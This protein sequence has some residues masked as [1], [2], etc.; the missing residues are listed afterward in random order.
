[1]LNLVIVADKD[2]REVNVPAFC[3][4]FVCDGAIGCSYGDREGEAGGDVDSAASAF[5]GM[6][7]LLWSVSA[8]KGWLEPLRE[9]ERMRHA[10][11]S[12]SSPQRKSCGGLPESTG[13]VVYREMSSL[14][15]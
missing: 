3:K 13:V 9:R 2:E 4:E 10:A 14:V 12:C 1:L 8:C 7:N 5:E 6:R 11:I 15:I